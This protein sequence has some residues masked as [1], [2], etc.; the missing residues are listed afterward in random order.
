[1]D[2]VVGRTTLRSDFTVELI[3]HM[4]NDEMIC[5]AARVSTL[6]S[7]SITSEESAGL[8]KF[9]MNNRHGSPFEHGAMTFLI[10][11]PIFVFRE[12]HRHRVGWSY[13]EMSGRYR[14]L[15]PVFYAPAPRRPLQQVGKPGAYTFVPGDE[16][17]QRVLDVT[18]KEAYEASWFSYENLLAHGVAKEVAR[19][20][21]PVGTYSAMY[22]TCNPRS[23]MHFLSLRTKD[24]ASKFPSYPQWE[25]EKVARGMEQY[26]A[27]LFP[28][29]Y[30]AFVANGRVAP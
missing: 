3:Q 28:I 26:F 4:G 13:N 19:Q 30:H 10:E 2:E 6:G 1:M 17:M 23:L 9:L 21:L 5:K 8:I 11:A 24:D 29:T 27:D 15:D 16:Q 18:S 20:V 14:Q 7:D 22:A 25:I 12:F